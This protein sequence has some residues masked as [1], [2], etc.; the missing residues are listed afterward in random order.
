MPAFGAEITDGVA[1][2]SVLHSLAEQEFHRYGRVVF[3]RSRPAVWPWPDREDAAAA[4]PHP[5]YF[6][7]LSG[8]HLLGVMAT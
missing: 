5:Q 6:V 2:R 3:R 8:V 4:S 7:A 1:V